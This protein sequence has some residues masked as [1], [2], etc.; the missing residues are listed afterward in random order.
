MS[1]PSA[2]SLTVV[3]AGLP[4]K[5]AAP[6]DLTPEQRIRWKAVVE[7]KP[8]DWFGQDSAPLLKE[9]VRAEAM[10]DLLSKQ[11]DEA[12]LGSRVQD[13]RLLLEM[14]DKESRRL[15]NLATKLRLTQQSRYTPQ[16]A[17]TAS[18]KAGNSRPWQT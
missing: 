15:A 11:V 9:Y 10:C 13:A 14:R 17:S 6:E 18:K 16:A 3:Q 12:M 8:N 7:S 2:S 1:K 4:E 5:L